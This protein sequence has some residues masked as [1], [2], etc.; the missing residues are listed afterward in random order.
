MVLMERIEQLIRR[1]DLCVLATSGDKGPHTSLMAYACLPEVVHLYLLTPINSLKYRNIV[2]NP[3]VSLLIDTREEVAREQVQALTVSG[4]ATVI[5]DPE[6]R[7][8][9]AA[10]LLARHPQLGAFP[11]PDKVAVLQIVPTA[12][13]LLDGVSTSHY[14]A[15][16]GGDGV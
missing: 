5:L 13:Q 9:I 1:K 3:V 2:Y 10:V 4:R 6:H 12:F 8:A 14:L 16:P 15:A 11:A 7:L